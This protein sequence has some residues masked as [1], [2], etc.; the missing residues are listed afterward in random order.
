MSY[1]KAEDRR[2][3][4]ID[5]ARRV[6]T[7]EGVGA[8]SMRA[9]AREAGTLLSNVSYVFPAKEGMLRAV[10]AQILEDF[11]RDYNLVVDSSL[12]VAASVDRG[13]RQLWHDIEDF[14]FGR[15]VVQYELTAHALR[16]DGMRD[17]AQWQYEQ[18]SAIVARW[19]N[20]LLALPDV[21]SSLHAQPLARLIVATMDGMLLQFLADPDGASTAD[22]L[23][24]LIRTVTGVVAANNDA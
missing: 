13:L 20:Q 15:Q 11:T 17:F 9:V 1:V 2:Q 22:V 21:D 12:P 19:C 10:Q 6:L 14:G 7:R 18:F 8:L 5:A 23:D 24:L 16:T 3:Q 4:V